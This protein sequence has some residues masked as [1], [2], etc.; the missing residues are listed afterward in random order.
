MLLEAEY[1]FRGEERRALLLLDGLRGEEGWLGLTATE[2]LFRVLRDLS[3]LKE[4]CSAP[5]NA[6]FG[7][8]KSFTSP[9]GRFIARKV[10]LGNT[11]TVDS[12]MLT[13][14]GWRLFEV[15]IAILGLCPV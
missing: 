3:A 12:S 13:P 1:N 7:L 4:Q 8:P 5:L 6:G 14:P 15:G 11:R 9:C 2:L 10:P